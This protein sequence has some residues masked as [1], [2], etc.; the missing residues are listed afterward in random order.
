MQHYDARF[1]ATKF[2]GANTFAKPFFPS[3]RKVDPFMMIW[4]SLTLR[5]MILLCKPFLW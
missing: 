2:F 3:F 1:V 4:S 5:H